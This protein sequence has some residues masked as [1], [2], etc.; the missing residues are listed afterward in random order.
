MKKIIFSKKAKNTIQK[1]IDDYFEYH[2]KLYS[3]TGIF[4]EYMI[5]E[6]YR[7]EARLRYE[8]IMLR[9]VNFLENEIISYKEDIAI[10][11]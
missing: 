9:I 4:T 2:K 3:D 10:L 6:N 1:Y 11:N 7:K 5:I 8:N